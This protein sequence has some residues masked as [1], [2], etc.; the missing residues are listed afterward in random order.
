MSEQEKIAYIAESV[1]MEPEELSRNQVLTELENWDSVAVLSMI[2]VF[3]EQLGQYPKAE[4][5]LKYTTVQDLM[6]AME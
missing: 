4:D 3:N 1:E 6:D 5:F 2:A